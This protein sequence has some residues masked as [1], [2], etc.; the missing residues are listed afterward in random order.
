MSVE[1]A[2]ATVLC[3]G[4]GSF[5]GLLVGGAGGQALYRIN[6]RYPPLLAGVAVILGCFPFWMVLN[7]VHATSSVFYIFVITAF[8]GLCA[9]VTGPVVKANLQNV[10]LPTARGQ[11]FA[12]YNTFDDFGRGLGPV[13]IA[14]LIS[15]YGSRRRAFNIGVLGWILCGFFNMLSAL[16]IGKDEQKM[17]RSLEVTLELVNGDTEQ[18]MQRKVTTNVINSKT[19]LVDDDFLEDTNILGVPHRASLTRRTSGHDTGIPQVK[20]V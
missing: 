15:K 14:M 19:V 16:T 2:T 1:G 8:A 9:G 12:I 20:V 13:F 17:H 18:K 3:F 7:T 10:T 4:I 5:C 11:A 6:P